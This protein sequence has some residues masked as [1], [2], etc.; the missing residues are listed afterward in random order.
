VPTRSTIRIERTGDVAPLTPRVER[1]FKEALSGQSLDEVQGSE[2]VRADYAC[3]G[4]LLAIEL[5][6]L[7]EDASERMDNLTEEL[8][9]R[10]DWPM[11]LG[12]APIDAFLKHLRDAEPVRRRVFERLGRAIINHV[13][14]ANKQ[15]G[16]HADTYPRKNLVRVTYLINEDHEV[17]DPDTVAYVLHRALR[18]MDVDQP[19]YP[20]IDAV[21][22]MTERHAARAGDCLAFPILSVE[23]LGVD[24]ALWKRD[25]IDHALTAWADWNGN[26]LFHADPRQQKFTVIDHIPATAPRHERWRT[27]YRR[28]PYMRAYD[29]ESLRKRFDECIVTSTLGM[30][31]NSPR[32]PDM[33]AT[34]ASM[35]LFTHV[36]VEMAE[37]AIPATDFQ[38]EPERL[39]AAAE[40]LGHS[41]DIV[42]WF[43]ANCGGAAKPMPPS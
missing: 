3:L 5:K 26:P 32:K 38:Y 30:L 12:S 7:E 21:I 8:S 36:M 23:G 2:I 4:G 10:D 39:A 34:M 19:L 27:E 6:T 28:H 33:K 15:L 16:A 31:K 9:K 17:Y 37:R 43:A 1:F 11:F 42:A 29:K 24:R 25:V 22:Y 41:D 35:Q 14:K 18:R 40:R 13:K 20:N